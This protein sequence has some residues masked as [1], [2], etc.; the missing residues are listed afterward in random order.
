MTNATSDKEN[1]T[2][3]KE[4]TKDPAEDQDIMEEVAGSISEVAEITILNTFY[5]SLFIRVKQDPN[6]SR[7]M[8][9]GLNHQSFLSGGQKVC[10]RNCS[11]DDFL[12]HALSVSDAFVGTDEF[13]PHR[14]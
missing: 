11:D 8:A 12:D 1:A 9:A 13:R 3:E 7:T 14:L 4:I 6:H 2:D 10:G 5:V